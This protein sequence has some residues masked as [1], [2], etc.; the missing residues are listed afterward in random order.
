MILIPKFQSIGA[1]FA[2]TCAELTVSVFQLLLIR[3]EVPLLSI[4]KLSIK[5]LI[6]GLVMII[7]LTFLN[8][9]KETGNSH[10]RSYPSLKYDSKCK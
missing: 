6:A 5:Y 4:L 8:R 2:S 1:A 10:I 7:S 3:K 9:F